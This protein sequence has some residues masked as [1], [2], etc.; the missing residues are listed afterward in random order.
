[1]STTF[2]GPCAGVMSKAAQQLIREGLPLLAA[3][4]PPKPDEVG[5][6]TR[7][8]GNPGIHC[9]WVPRSLLRG[10]LRVHLASLEQPA[11]AG[12]VQIAV[13]CPNGDH[14]AGL[15]PMEDMEAAR[16]KHRSTLS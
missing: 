4:P 7:P 5:L 15:V 11:P 6:L 2:S 8:D 9:G 13:I 16:A 1:M 3:L 10:L 12:F 14:A